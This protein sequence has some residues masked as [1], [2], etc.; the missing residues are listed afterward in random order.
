MDSIQ[1]L[2]FIELHQQLGMMKWPLTVMSVVTLMILIE[3]ILYMVLNSRTHTVP[4]LRQ[5]HQLDFRDQASVNQFIDT[6]LNGRSL[7]FQ[8]MRMLLNH[9]HFNK[10]LREEAV[11]IWLF[12]KRQQFRSGIRVLSLIGVISPLIGLLGTVM[13]LMEMFDG[14]SSTGNVNP[15]A[16][17]DGLGLAMSTTA[18]GLIIAVPAISGAQVLNMWVD[19]TLSKIEYTLNHSNLHIEG[20]TVEASANASNSIE[21]VKVSTPKTVEAGI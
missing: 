21:S 10:Q 1:Q 8:S 12:K 11:S 2:P 9:R 20:I 4:I 13:G 17:A 14:L 7:V 15:A 16:L 5:V 6:Q 18:V 3:R 19:K